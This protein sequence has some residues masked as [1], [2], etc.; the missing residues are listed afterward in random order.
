[1]ICADFLV[2]VSGEAGDTEEL[3]TALSRYFRLLP[4]EQQFLFRDI[5]DAEFSK[6]PARSALSPSS[7]TNSDEKSCAETFD[8]AKPAE[9]ASTCG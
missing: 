9:V 6:A 7:T 8:P 3:E 2:G 4:H 1:M 5:I